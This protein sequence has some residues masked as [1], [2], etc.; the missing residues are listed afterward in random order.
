MN[1]LKIQAF[2]VIIIAV[3]FGFS[4]SAVFAETRIGIL[5]I[6]RLMQEAPQV[7]KARLELQVEFAARETEINDLQNEL[8]KL[9]GQSSRTAEMNETEISD[10][11][12]LIITTHRNLTGVQEEF[13]ADYDLERDLIL[14]QLEQDII[15]AATTF[16]ERNQYDL[17]LTENVVYSS[18]QIDITEAVLK[19]LSE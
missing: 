3:F 8:I 18:E 11:E 2:I 1:S 7:K 10:L 14:V 5:N 19:V 13:R 12:Q 16:A 17:I 9:E 15:E 6:A 4:S